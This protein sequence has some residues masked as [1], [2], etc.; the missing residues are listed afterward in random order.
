MGRGSP[1]APP[2]VILFADPGRSGSLAAR[3]R[4]KAWHTLA[5]VAT[6][7]ALMYALHG[8]GAADPGTEMVIRLR[9]MGSTALCDVTTNG[10]RN[11]EAARTRGVT[12]F[13]SYPPH[14]GLDQPSPG[15]A[16]I[17]TGGPPASGSCRTV[18]DVWPFELALKAANPPS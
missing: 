6:G 12:F 14:L 1:P 16:G 11:T 9:L 13:L 5:L 15:A 10:P 4:A 8:F 7:L 2:C 18:T 17:F 3:G